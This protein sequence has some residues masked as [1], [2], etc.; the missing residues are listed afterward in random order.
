MKNIDIQTLKPKPGQGVYVFQFPVR[1]WHWT[2]VCCIFTLFITGHFIGKPPQ[3]LQGDPTRLFYFGLLIKAHYT[4][5]LILC[6]AMLCRILYAFVGNSVS[7][8]IFIPHI[9]QKSWWD[10]FFDSIKW[11]LFINK[12]PGICMGHNP[13]AQAAMWLVVMALIF[14]CLSGLGIYQAKGYSSLLKGFS[15]MENLAYSAGGNGMNL[16]VWHRLGMVIVVIFVM[17]HIYMVIREDIMGRTTIISTMISGTRLVKATPLE[18][19]HDLQQEEAH[20]KHE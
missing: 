12:N 4:A 18:D 13:L 5:G 15:F 3:T 2:I 9:W 19:W 1:L 8:Q 11:Y 7:R 14:M 20:I 16:V 10:G 17:A 6:V